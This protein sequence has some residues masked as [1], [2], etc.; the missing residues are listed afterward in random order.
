MIGCYYATRDVPV[1]I[2]AVGWFGLVFLAWGLVILFLQ[3]FRR[4]PTVI[5]DDSGVLDRRLGVGPIPWSDI[6]SVSITLVRDQRFISLWLRNEKQYLDRI[7]TW[8]RGARRLS[9]RMGYS[10]F[11]LTFIGLTP[12]LDEAYALLRSRLPE[13]TGF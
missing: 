12:G 5:I 1:L 2:Q 11:A 10:P 4:G 7:P 9:E 3:F 6:T 13:R 8:R